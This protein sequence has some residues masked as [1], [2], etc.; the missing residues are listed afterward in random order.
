ME[1]I[2]IMHHGKLLSSDMATAKSQGI[3]QDDIILLTTRQ[4]LRGA[5]ALQQQT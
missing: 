5:Q 4:A 1:D 2:I 3:K